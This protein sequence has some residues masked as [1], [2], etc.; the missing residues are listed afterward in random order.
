MA[1]FIEP[2]VRYSTVLF[3]CEN[4][5]QSILFYIII[6]VKEKKKLD[7]TCECHFFEKLLKQFIICNL[8]QFN[9]L[10]KYMLHRA[11]INYLWTHI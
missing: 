7:P 6:E 4:K 1:K 3:P 8:L 11:F 10:F 2:T 5:T 9:F